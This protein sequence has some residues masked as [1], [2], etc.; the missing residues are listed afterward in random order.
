MK[1]SLVLLWMQNF[2]WKALNLLFR[3]GQF[4]WLMKVRQNWLCALSLSLF[5]SRSLPLL[6]KP[7]C[8]AQR[9][10]HSACNSLR[11][12]FGTIELHAF[13]FSQWKAKSCNQLKLY[14]DKSSWVLFSAPSGCLLLC[15][16]LSVLTML[17]QNLWM[18]PDITRDDPTGRSPEEEG[19]IS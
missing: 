11:K 1:D 14:S 16:C 9:N 18:P 3:D 6:L 17:L 13:Y 12:S 5:L 8:R 15:L 10:K 4:T 19:K 2:K 7:I